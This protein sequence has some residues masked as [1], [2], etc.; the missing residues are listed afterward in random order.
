MSFK[1][2]NKNTCHLKN[3]S[4]WF[5]MCIGVLLACMFV[6]GYLVPCYRQ[7][8][9]SMWVTGIEPWFSGKAASAL[10]YWLDLAH[11]SSIYTYISISYNILYKIYR[12]PVELYGKS[13]Y[14]DMYFIIGKGEYRWKKQVV[15]DKGK[16][17]LKTF[18][19]PK[20]VQNQKVG[21]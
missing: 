12:L 7:L 9:A 11:L 19:T 14:A 18:K 21:D 2:E 10:E 4:F 6:W 16:D 15:L 8:W 1:S 13:V 5:F 20:I 17:Q 3:D